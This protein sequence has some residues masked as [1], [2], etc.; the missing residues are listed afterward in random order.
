MDDQP[1]PDLDAAIDAV[2]PSLTAVSD[3][4][5]ANS[6]RRT[7]VA[8][9]GDGSGRERGDRAQFVWR[10]AIPAAAVAAAA[11]AAVAVWAGALA[12]GPVVTVGE[13]RPVA[14]AAGTSAGSAAIHEP[15][16][17]A[18]APRTASRD[19]RVESHTAR[20]DR[21]RDDRMPTA[22]AA[23][24]VARAP[25]PDPLAALVRAADS[26]PEEA[27]AAGIDPARAQ[28]VLP[29]VPLTAIADA[30]LETPPI[31][32]TPAEPVAPGEP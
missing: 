22:R 5:A 18:A 31:L 14:P 30:P 4:A 11:I 20:T 32:D 26:I 19:G 12:E 3:D 10:W 23:E 21:R 7:R 24:P 17:P 25:R 13:S 27:W 9:S 15:P 6:L 8:L 2:V 1:R 28:L 16:T 29:D